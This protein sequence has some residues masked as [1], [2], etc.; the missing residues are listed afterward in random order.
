MEDL[1]IVIR[2]AMQDVLRSRSAR[3]A[4]LNL[5]AVSTGTEQQRAKNAAHMHAQQEAFYMKQHASACALQD[6]HNY[7]ALTVREASRDREIAER[8]WT[9]RFPVEQK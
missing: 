7:H 2:T 3:T 1:N 8:L 9:L 5:A 4:A 6:A